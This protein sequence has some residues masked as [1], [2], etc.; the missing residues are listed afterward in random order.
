MPPNLAAGNSTNKAVIRDC[1]ISPLILQSPPNVKAQETYMKLGALI[2]SLRFRFS[3]SDD[4]GEG[5]S[6]FKN[7]VSVDPTA[8]GTAFRRILNT[9]KRK[10]R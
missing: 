2:L 8:H 1:E 3:L 9:G 4:G 6:A 7:G 5:L 10:P